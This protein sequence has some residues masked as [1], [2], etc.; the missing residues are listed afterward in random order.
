MSNTEQDIDYTFYDKPKFLSPKPELD[1]NIDETATETIEPSDEV[2]SKVAGRFSPKKSPRSIFD[3]PK[4]PKRRRSKS[5]KRKTKSP[6]RKKSPKR[7]RSKSPK[8]RSFG[9]RIM[10]GMGGLAYSN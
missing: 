10:S 9:L 1:I 4:N 5:P 8:K 3:R 6:K 7:R 2:L